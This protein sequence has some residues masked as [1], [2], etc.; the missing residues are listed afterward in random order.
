MKEFSTEEMNFSKSRKIIA[1][2]IKSSVRRFVIAPGSRSAP[3]ALSIAENPLAE[4][5]VHFDERGAAFHALGIAKATNHPAVV[6]CTSGTALANF[7]PAVMEAYHSRTPLIL[8]SAD[9]PP[10]LQDCGSNQ[11]VDQTKPFGNFLRFEVDL[12]CSD[13][14]VSLDYIAS[15]INQ[16]IYR[17]LNSPKGPVLINA[18]FREPFYELPPTENN[19][20]LPLPHTRY[21]PYEKTLSPSSFSYIA[22]EFSRRERGI[23]VVGELP[24]EENIEAILS[25]AMRLQWPIFADPLSH[26]R[27]IGRD[28][29]MIAYYNHILLTTPAREKL[30]PE[31]VLYLGGSI[32]SKPLLKWLGSIH[33]ENFYHVGDFPSRQDPYQK[34]TE[35]VEMRPDTF[36]E[37]IIEVLKGRAPST[38][39]S[40]WKEYSL[41][42]EEY[43]SD[44]IGNVEELSEL[45]SV[46]LL[47]KHSQI[48][49]AFFVG[50]SLPIRFFDSFFFPKERSA[51]IFANRGVS[52]IDGNIATALGIAK[53]LK[54]PLIV[55]L[56]D[57]T[58][59]HDINSLALA[60]RY[61]LPIVFI[62]FNNKGGGLFHFLPMAQEKKYFSE[63]FEAP[64]QVEIEKVAAGFGIPYF[65]PDSKS[66]FTESIETA[67]QQNAPAIIEI[68]ING[69]ETYDLSVEIESFLQKKISKGKKGNKACYFTLSKTH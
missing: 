5:V 12:H 14:F 52:G 43:L 7:Y 27:K 63:F 19:S 47:I 54:E 1:E 40:L 50:N 51:T 16:A 59:L 28:S 21:F 48:G 9:R 13:P 56:G 57:L 42:V 53:G 30:L 33:P 23:I 49:G 64:H 46:D 67:I 66:T 32:V 34:V 65:H 38:W 60:K 11:T 39:L 8:L 26:L 37:K 61:P 24:Q 4:S 68:T 45:T 35:R 31:I 69:K 18:K 17:S 10:E 36:C 15:S 29:S 41:S 25:L 20:I 6:V 44:F 55:I 3:L 58:F 62:I 2:C 22:S